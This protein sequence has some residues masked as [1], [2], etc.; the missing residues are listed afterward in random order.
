MAGI[1]KSKSVRDE[2][3]QAYN[4]SRGIGEG[5]TK[6]I[7][8]FDSM[9]SAL[10]ASGLVEE[11]QLPLHRVGVHPHNRGGKAMSGKTMQAKGSKI[12]S[13]GVSF[14]LCMP[15]RCVCFEVQ[16]SEI[17]ER[18]Q[19]T[20]KHSKLFGVVSE[21][22]NFGSVGCSH[23]NQFLHC[24][25]DRATTF[26][27]NLKVPGGTTIDTDRLYQQDPNL[28]TLCEHGLTWSVINRK[29]VDQ[30]ADLPNLFQ[31]A[32]NV[33]HHIAEGETWD[34]QLLNI[35]RLAQAN[36]K[37]KS[38]GT[39]VDWEKVQR[40][41]RQSAGPYV[42]D[43]PGHIGFLKKYGGGADQVLAKDLIAYLNVRMPA[44]RK[45]SG[46]IIDRVGE[47]PMT[48]DFCIPHFCNALITALATCE[49][50]DCTD[51]FAGLI[52]PSD[53]QVAIGLRQL[54]KS[55]RP[56]VST[57]VITDLKVRSES[58]QERHRV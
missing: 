31:Q 57:I 52:G 7:Q 11:M 15:D 56:S 33:E 51:G 16:G 42:R 38:Q 58:T 41:V 12:V 10:K 34:Q 39:V 37:S 47:I 24:V 29:V 22:C 32:L 54:H 4:T 20:V 23:L 48:P 36:S 6:V 2:F 53:I 30:Y 40:M 18:M 14:K 8:N 21:N 25:R 44:G 17:V 46:D 55:P 19:Y 26:E 35:A 45:V 1:F 13:V 3:E 50:K 5:D 49:E 9:M 43:A 28:K 27:A